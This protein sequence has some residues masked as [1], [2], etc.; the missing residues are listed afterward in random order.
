MDRT[1]FASEIAALLADDDEAA[2]RVESELAK[3]K[4]VRT[5]VRHRLR[6][7]LTQK[8]VAEAMGCGPS[9][10]S[11]LES[12]DDE[13]LKWG[14]IVRYAEAV[15]AKLN[16]MVSDEQLPVADQIKHHVLLIHERLEELKRLAERV[17]HDESI[18]SKIDEFYGQVLF[19]FLLRFG[20]SY[21]SFQ[22]LVPTVSTEENACCSAE[23]AGTDREEV[24]Q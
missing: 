3:N 4:L 5:L 22:T 14:D 1:E 21:S 7:D 9:K 23:P 6:K 11:K 24:K 15:D 18:V 8:Q 2:Q 20:D 10:I 12:G 17:P 19:N 16:L 13:S